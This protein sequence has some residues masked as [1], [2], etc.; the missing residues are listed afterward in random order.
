MLGTHLKSLKSRLKTVRDVSK[1]I[2]KDFGFCKSI[3]GTL[4]DSRFFTLKKKTLPFNS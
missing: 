1:D 4:R 3:M 2:K